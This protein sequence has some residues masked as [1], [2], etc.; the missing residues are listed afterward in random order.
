GIA[1]ITLNRPH[2]LNAR[3]RQLRRELAASFRA[4]EEDPGIVVAVVTG[5]G[6]RAFSVG[7][8]L[9]EAAA[10]VD[11]PLTSRRDWPKES[12]A[13][14]LDAVT[15]PVIAAVNGYCLGGGLELALCCD[16]RIASETAQFA[17][18]EGLRG[19]MPGAGGTQRLPRLIGPSRA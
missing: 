5:A 11:D 13:V 7:M 8:D 12:D 10:S 3:N 1:F 19:I 2:A 4:V 6:D 15:K 18:P 14:A 9:K 17:L 16:F